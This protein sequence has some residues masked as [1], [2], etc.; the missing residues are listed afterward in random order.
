MSNLISKALIISLINLLVSLSVF[1]EV[2]NNDENIICETNFLTTFNIQEHAFVKDYSFSC[3]EKPQPENYNKCNCLKSLPFKVKLGCNDL[4]KI[5]DVLDNKSTALAATL[6]RLD[7]YTQKLAQV[8][9]QIKSLQGEN[10]DLCNIEAQLKE[11]CTEKKLDEINNT[12]ERFK[13][14]NTDPLLKPLG[15][16]LE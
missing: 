14:A 9:P 7:E 15:E 10:K 3:Y 5:H 4:E 1:S 16:G 2:E 6:Y 12:F 8:E 11:S 13:I